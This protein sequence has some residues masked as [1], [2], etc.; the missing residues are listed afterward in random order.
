MKKRSKEE[1]MGIPERFKQRI[2]LSAL[3]SFSNFLYS[4]C[5]I[6]TDDVQSLKQELLTALLPGCCSLKH[7]KAQANPF[8]PFEKIIQELISTE[9]MGH[10]YPITRT[11][12]VYPRKLPNGAEIW[13]YVR[14]YNDKSDKHADK[15]YQDICPCNIVSQDT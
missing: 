9:N 2:L 13:G 7:E 14:L 15:K 6:S 12:Q 4:S 10:F 5:G 8:P 1:K 11:G 3:I